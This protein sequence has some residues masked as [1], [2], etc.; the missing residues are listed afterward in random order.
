LQQARMSF[1]LQLRIFQR[2]RRSSIHWA[3]RFTLPPGHSHL[4]V[5]F[6]PPTGRSNPQRLGTVYHLLFMRVG[7]A[8]AW[9]PIRSLLAHADAGMMARI[10]PCLD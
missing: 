10:F 2:L 4:I 3:F 1:L 8:G 7:C 6:F 9:H 5:C